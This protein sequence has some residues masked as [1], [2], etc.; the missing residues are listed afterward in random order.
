MSTQSTSTPTAPKGLHYIPNFLTK[1]EAKDIYD[2]LQS[3]TWSS[4]SP[5]PNSRRVIHYGWSYPYNGGKLE[6]TTP[7]PD[8][9]KPIMAK[10]SS[11][12][13]LKD[14]KP[15]QVIVNEYKPGQGIAFHTDD[16]V[17]SGPIIVCITVG[18]GAE[19]EFSRQGMDN[20][21]V[22]TEPGSLYI[23]SGESRNKWKHCMRRRK[24][25]GRRP[26]GT[27]VSI[28]FREAIEI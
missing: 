20:Y 13:Q 25:D 15:N 4:V 23:M 21:K 19:M 16:M 5:H 8:M 10:L 17:K 9:I 1:E 18:D 11:I 27:R 3:S 24:S 2:Q 7:I 12:E 14:F 26:R 22:Y 6:Q 28:T